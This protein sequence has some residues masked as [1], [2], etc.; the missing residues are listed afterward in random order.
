MV[1]VC[2]PFSVQRLGLI[3]SHDLLGLPAEHILLANDTRLRKTIEIG[4]IIF[5]SLFD[6]ADCYLHVHVSSN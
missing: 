1:C 3:P 2:T 6:S 4:S 5:V